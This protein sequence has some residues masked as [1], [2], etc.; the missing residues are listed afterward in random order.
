MSV[1]LVAAIGTA[2]GVALGALGTVIVNV[3]KA[4]KTKTEDK[5]L[6]FNHTENLVKLAS[7]QSQEI[8][9]VKNLVQSIQERVV[10]LTESQA[11]FNR[12]YLRHSILRVYFSYEQEKEIP[13]A[14][15]E[16]VL[17]LYDVYTSL[18]GNGFVHEKIDEMKSWKKI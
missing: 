18:N 17:G 4:K 10:E 7:G 9:E 11:S 1:E 14:E 6:E 12:M 15:W 13:M 16:S 5:E 8:G 3:I 2:I